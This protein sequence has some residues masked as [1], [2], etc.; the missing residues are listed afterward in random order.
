MRGG[1]AAPRPA[2]RD[3]QVTQPGADDPAK[4]VKIGFVDIGSGENVT[5]T[6]SH[7]VH[8]GLLTNV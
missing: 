3:R 1:G 7:G 2:P 4:S 6:D 5:F 8:C